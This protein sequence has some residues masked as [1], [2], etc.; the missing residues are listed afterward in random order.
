[1]AKKK[2]KRKFLEAA[3][4]LKTDP[5]RVKDEKFH[6]QDEFFDPIDKVQV[7][8]EMLRSH[9]VDGESVTEAARRFGYTRES[10]Y[11]SMERLETEGIL[12]LVDR[13]LRRVYLLR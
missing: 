13:K 2:D 12:G 6:R 8:Y 5:E 9:G 11:Q 7:K 10:F 3:G 4:A 1:M